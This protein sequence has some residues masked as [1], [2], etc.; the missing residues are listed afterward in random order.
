M[1]HPRIFDSV[2]MT[3]I[4]LLI[5]YLNLE[6]PRI[7]VLL[8]R[9][10]YLEAFGSPD[11]LIYS[12]TS[13]ISDITPTRLADKID[14]LVDNMKVAFETYIKTVPS[15]VAYARSAIDLRRQELKL[16][17]LKLRLGSDTG[18]QDAFHEMGDTT[19]PWYDEVFEDDIS[20]EQTICDN[21]RVKQDHKIEEVIAFL[22]YYHPDPF[23]AVTMVRHQ[24]NGIIKE[25][26]EAMD[27]PLP[28]DVF[29]PLF[30][31]LEIFNLEKGFVGHEVDSE[32]ESVELG[33]G[34]EEVEEDED[35]KDDVPEP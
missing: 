34:G 27:Q 1:P 9:M 25:V 17:S 7:I 18:L 11:E 33:E 26:F 32:T 19:S 20:V 28:D 2:L 21:L 24:T 29:E 22:E 14:I 5:H 23:D 6:Y 16:N 4:N 30:E 12:R 15:V 10:S 8:L 35:V 31:E 3:D 13:R